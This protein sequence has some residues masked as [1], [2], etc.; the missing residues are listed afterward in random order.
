MVIRSKSNA[1]NPWTGGPVDDVVLRVRDVRVSFGELQV[2]KGVDLDVVRGEILG[3]VGGSGSGKSV[4]MRSILGLIK[5]EQGQI[6]LLGADYDSI[7]A[8]EKLEIDRS[9]GVL[10]QH[11]ALFSSLMGT[12]MFSFTVREENRAP[13]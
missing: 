7:S 11:G 1:A 5:K 6:E 10:F 13:C 4:L 3:F 12:C 9:L 8:A 2:L